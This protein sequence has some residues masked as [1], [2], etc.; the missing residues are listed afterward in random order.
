[1]A[2]FTDFRRRIAGAGG[3]LAASIATCPLDVVKTKLQAQK[4]IP[5]QRGYLG[6]LGPCGVF[7]HNVNMG[8]F[9]HFCRHCKGY[10]EGEWG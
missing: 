2:W 9:N 5:G 10:F 3:G 1:M 6:I 7:S 8:S 4:A